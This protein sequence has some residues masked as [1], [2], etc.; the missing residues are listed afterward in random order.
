MWVYDYLECDYV[1][2]DV[3]WGKDTGRKAGKIAND[4]SKHYPNKNEARILRR[5]RS[6]TGL[7]EQEIR[8]DYKYRK[9]LSEAQK[10]GQK[11][12]YSPTEKFWH[13]LIQKAC[14][15]TGLAKEH[16]DTLAALDCIIE[17]HFTRS[18]WRPLF[19]EPLPAKVVVENYGK[20]YKKK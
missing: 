1:W 10:Q 18:W 6:Q 20:T 15:E 5:I 19:T 16:P 2:H 12:K 11:P 14:R 4:P 9:M 8:R 7:S 17:D 13:N 3:C